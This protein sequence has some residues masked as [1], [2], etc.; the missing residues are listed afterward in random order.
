MRLPLKNIWRLQLVQN[1]VSRAVIVFLKG[2][3]SHLCLV[4]YIDH[5][6]ACRYN[7]RC[8]FS[9]LKLYVAWDQVIWWTTSP[10]L[11]LCVPSGSSGDACGRS[12]LVPSDKKEKTSLFYY[13]VHSMEHLL[14]WGEVSPNPNGLS[15][16]LQNMIYFP[17]R[18]GDPL[19]AE[20]PC[21]RCTMYNILINH[22]AIL[23]LSTVY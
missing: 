6:L 10:Q 16:S 14:P 4:S 3:I 17:I 8:C 22:L 19:A 20:C 18:P 13:D 2:H 15:E 23:F 5:Q 9:P 1:E 21:I 12:C 11:L 7:S